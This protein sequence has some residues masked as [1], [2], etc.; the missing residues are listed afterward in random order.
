MCG[1]V[2]AFRQASDFGADKNYDRGGSFEFGAGLGIGDPHEGKVEPQ[3][4]EPASGR[5]AAWDS[6]APHKIDVG[7]RTR[8]TNGAM[9]MK[10]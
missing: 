4:S 6:R 7:T 5:D 1:G 8:S 9:E 3:R 2:G 10:P